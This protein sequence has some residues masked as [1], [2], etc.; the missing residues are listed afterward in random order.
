MGRERVR[1][2]TSGSIVGAWDWSRCRSDVTAHVRRNLLAAIPVVLGVSVMAFALLHLLPG[3][4]A[5][6]MLGDSG[7]PPERIAELRA[8]LGLD[9]PLVLQYARFLGNLLRGDLGRS[10]HSNRPVLEAIRQQAPDT[11]ALTL[12]GLG[13]AVVLGIPLGVLAACCRRRLAR[14]DECGPVTARHLA[15]VILA[16]HAPHLRVR[17]L[18]RVAARHGPGRHGATDPARPHAGRA[19]HGC[20]RVGHAREDERGART[21]VRDDGARQ[22]D[23]G[24]P[25]GGSGTPSRMRWSPLSRSW[26]S[27]SVPCSA[28]ASSSRTSSP[29]RVWGDWRSRRSSAGTSPLSRASWSSPPWP[30]C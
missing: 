2:P 26:D 21:G 24:G 3:D 5:L 16:R 28:E 22:G 25:T 17:P 13:L 4:P 20:D 10:I 6:V 27:S 19:R 14:P 18:A 8:Q 30:T 7:G 23:V 29:G 11:I 12:A 15:A 1:V 9:D